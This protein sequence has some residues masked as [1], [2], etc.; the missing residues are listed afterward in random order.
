MHRFFERLAQVRTALHTRP[1][2]FSDRQRFRPFRLSRKDAHRIELP[3]LPWDWYKEPAGTS[4]PSSVPRTSI[5]KD[6]AALPKGS[7][8]RLDRCLKRAVL[9]Y[10]AN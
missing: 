9:Y 1:A 4:P 6:T 10:G 8:A 5:D 3:I 7:F 2:A